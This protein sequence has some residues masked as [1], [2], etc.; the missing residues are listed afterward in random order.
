MLLFEKIADSKIPG[1]QNEY[2]LR[3]ITE[4]VYLK[5]ESLTPLFIKYSV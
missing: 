2:L 3:R 4:R 5:I 1:I